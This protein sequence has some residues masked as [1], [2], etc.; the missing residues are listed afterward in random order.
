MY[1]INEATKDEVLAKAEETLSGIIDDLKE[2]KS[3]EF[4]KGFRLIRWIR[5]KMMSSYKTID[6]DYNLNEFCNGCGICASVCPAR[7][8]E[9]V[10]GKPVFKHHCEHCLACIHWCPQRAINYGK[11]TQKRKRYHHPK[12]EVP[13]L[14]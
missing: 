3:N 1:D 11:K 10:T 4:K 12:V 14:P 5:G 7:N 9:I 2:R 13:Q 8:I 6:K